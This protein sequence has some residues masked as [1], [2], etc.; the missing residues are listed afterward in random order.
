MVKENAKEVNEN[1]E[2]T[3]I[4]VWGEMRKT[5]KYQIIKRKDRNLDLTK[6]LCE[7]V[8]STCTCNLLSIWLL[9]VQ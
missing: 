4:G 9:C 1:Q 3:E 7:L 8:R 5:R 2:G 6:D